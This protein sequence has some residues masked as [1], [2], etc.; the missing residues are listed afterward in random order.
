M[1]AATLLLLAPTLAAAASIALNTTTIPHLG[2]VQATS[3]A[4]AGYGSY[5]LSTGAF[6]TLSTTPQLTPGGGAINARCWSG[7]ANGFEP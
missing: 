5:N 7:F 3:G 2:W 4:Y 6:T 1:R